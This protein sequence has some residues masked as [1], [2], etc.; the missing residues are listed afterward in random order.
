VLDGG[1]D[2]GRAGGKAGNP[3]DPSKGK[4]DAETRMTLSMAKQLLN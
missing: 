2:G 1:R 4:Y 3:D